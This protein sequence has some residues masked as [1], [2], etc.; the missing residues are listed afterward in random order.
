[1]KTFLFYGSAVLVAFVLAA[2]ITSCGS[3]NPPGPSEKSFVVSGKFIEVKG[4]VKKA[5][6]SDAKSVVEFAVNQLEN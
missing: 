2:A 1:M 6:V 3:E 4:L 5:S